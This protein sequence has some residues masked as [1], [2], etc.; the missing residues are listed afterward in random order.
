MVIGANGLS[1][2]LGKNFLEYSN[3]NFPQWKISPCSRKIDN[4]Q[5]KDTEIFINFSSPSDVDDFKN[6]PMMIQSMLD[7]VYNNIKI[8]NQKKVKFVFCSS[9]ATEENELNIYGAF[10]LAIEK[11]LESK[12]L[13][14]EYL[15]IRI[16]RV[17]SKDRS[18]G[19]MKLLRE[20]RV[21]KEDM[22]KTVEFI[23]IED[24]IQEFNN[25]INKFYKNELQ[26]ETI[27]IYPTFMATI[28]DI[29]ELYKL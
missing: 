24:F 12:I 1:G 14:I 17:Y 23:D 2:F 9:I 8:C 22:I 13:P 29:K 3:L 27:K 21:S 16:P 25:I 19:L 5:I 4:F 18:K 6:V 28:K 7:E 26:N 15:I 11:F 10:K 20:D